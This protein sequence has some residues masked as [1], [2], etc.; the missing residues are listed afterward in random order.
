MLCKFLVLIIHPRGLEI[1]SRLHVEC[2][3][4]I[5]R[6]HLLTGFYFYGVEYF[7]SH[8]AKCYVV[9]D[10]EIEVTTEC[11]TRTK[12]PSSGEVVGFIHGVV[13]QSGEIHLVTS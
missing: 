10:T 7:F 11:H 4:T 6:Q 2:I 3:Q 12:I 8:F 13:D 9:A 1:V 5:S